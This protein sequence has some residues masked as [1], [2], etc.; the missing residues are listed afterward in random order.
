[1]CVSG[2]CCKR[3]C[4]LNLKRLGD[5]DSTC[6]LQERLMIGKRTEENFQENRLVP[7]WER[8]WRRQLLFYSG[9]FSK[10]WFYNSGYRKILQA[11]HSKSYRFLASPLCLLL[12]KLKHPFP[13]EATPVLLL[14]E[15]K[16]W[17][18]ILPLKKGSDLG[19]TL[20][21]KLNNTKCAN[22]HIVPTMYPKF[23]DWES[24][25]KKVMM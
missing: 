3:C 19:I 11:W 15:K 2:S 16:E 1:M 4:E 18:Q 6:L 17:W 25:K 10:A 24:E 23:S 7:Q 13:N 22:Y 21:P 9:F 5:S 14:S 8:M 20:P 12:W